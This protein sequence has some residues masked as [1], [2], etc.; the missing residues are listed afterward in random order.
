MSDSKIVE[1]HGDQTL[2]KAQSLADGIAL[3]A[4]WRRVLSVRWLACAVVAGALGNWTIAMG[5]PGP[6]RFIVASGYSGGVLIP[7]LILY[8]LTHKSD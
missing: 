8:W 3:V 1:L 6:W 2:E 5:W 7:V 4:R